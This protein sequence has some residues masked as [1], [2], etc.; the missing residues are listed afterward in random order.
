MKGWQSLLC[1][2]FMLMNVH[3]VLSDREGSKADTAPEEDTERK[4]KTDAEQRDELLL[5]IKNLQEEVKLLHENVDLLRMSDKDLEADLNITDQHTSG[6]RRMNSRRKR[7]TSGSGGV[8]VRWGRALCPPSSDLVYIGIAAGPRH[9]ERGG[10]SNYICLSSSPEYIDPFAGQQGDRSRIYSVEYQL[11]DSHNDY[12]DNSDVPCAVCRARERTTVL[13]IPGRYSCPNG[14][15]VEYNGFIV[16][17]KYTYYRTEFVCL[18]R[19]P[20]S[21]STP[22]GDSLNSE[23][24]LVEAMKSPNGGICP[25]YTDGYEVTCAVCSI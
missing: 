19:Y 23:M 4:E 13:M 1:L 24:F 20:T 5:V 6:E 3:T 10:G 25:P 21:R 7:T 14:W 8:Y 15:Q 12:L 18:D 17:D 9:D 22:Q 11:A 2:S 16:A